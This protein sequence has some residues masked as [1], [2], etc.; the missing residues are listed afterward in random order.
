MLLMVLVAVK[1][2]I[3]Y[4]YTGQKELIAGVIFAIA[5]L[6]GLFYFSFKFLLGAFG[7]DISVDNRTLLFINFGFIFLVMLSWFYI[8]YQFLY[9]NNNSVRILF[10]LLVVLNVI[11]ES[12]FISVIFFSSILLETVEII[13]FVYDMFALILT[14]VFVLILAIKSMIS[15][16]KV[17]KYRGLFLLIGFILGG[18]S[19]VF[20]NGIFNAEQAIIDIIARLALILGIFII[21]FGFFMT[22]ESRIYKLLFE[23][24]TE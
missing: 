20:D 18:G 3:N 16:D 9:P 12:F 19:L 10:Y 17:L 23:K 24:K 22:S 7:I 14:G 6:A 4:K 21:F 15:K 2:F 11:W 8:F 5:F 13:V 1:F